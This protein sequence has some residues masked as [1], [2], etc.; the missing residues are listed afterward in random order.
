FLAGP[1]AICRNG[2]NLPVRRD[3]RIPGL[4]LACL[5]GGSGGDSF[6]AKLKDSYGQERDHIY[7]KDLYVR[8]NFGTPLHMAAIGG[9]LAAMQSLLS[10]YELGNEIF[11]E[12][13][14]REE[15]RTHHLDKENSVKTYSGLTALHLAIAFGH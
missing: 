12:T 6:V 14:E 9:N 3:G 13:C 10:R 1:L 5:L 15:I 11:F 7:R 2:S 4:H 8:S